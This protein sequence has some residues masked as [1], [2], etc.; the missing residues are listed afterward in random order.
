MDDKLIIAET[1]V[2]IATT[3]FLVERGVIPYQFSVAVGRGIDTA[4][5]TVRLRNAFSTF[6]HIPQF[7]GTGADV[8]GLS[9]SEWWAVE[10]KGA[11]V[12]KPPTQR[13]NFDRALASVVSYYED[14]P[15]GIEIENRNVTV[16]L[17]LALPDTNAYLKELR[18]RVRSPL[19]KRLN[20]WILL[21]QQELGVIQAISPDETI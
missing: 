6:G 7:S 17:G 20:M 14:I 11:G 19:R 4:G 3:A 2:L 15:Q 10:C 5:A 12:G 16:C 13:N 8:M 9:D 21:Y 18:R 1:D